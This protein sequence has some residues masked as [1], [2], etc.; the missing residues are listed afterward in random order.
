MAVVGAGVIGLSVAVNLSEEYGER[1]ELTVIAD[2]FSPNTTSD[3]AGSVI[4]PID[5]SVEAS[6][7]QAYTSRVQKWTRASFK[8]F[9]ALYKSELN[10]ELQ[11]RLLT[12]YDFK[13][14]LVSDPWWK[15]CVFGFRHID[16]KSEEAK[17]V[18]A[19][20]ESYSDIW[21]FT[22]Y[23]IDC[24]RYLPWM[25][26]IF[27][28][29]GGL[30]EQRR[31][32]N[33]QE[34][35]SYDIVINCTGL[36][37]NPL[38]N[39]AKLYP[40]RGQAILVRAPWVT[41]FSICY[42]DPDKMA[43]ILPRADDVLLGGTAQAHDWNES[44]DPKTADEIMSRCSELVPSISNA[45]VIDSWAGLRP[46]RQEVRLEMERL[47][48]AKRSCLIHCYGHGGQGIVLHWGCAMEVGELVGQWLS[49]T[50]SKL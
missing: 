17:L 6:S 37:A 47:N 50:F 10:S 23:M 15:D 14:T 27:T 13:S 3:K 21:V 44:T 4:I 11:I 43:Y 16:T 31:I 26:R 1:A 24:R 32:E 42:M 9:F 38:L 2:A 12:G 45:E 39:D 41:H 20:P 35:S 46:V 49:E 29:N 7:D 8:R 19:K 48:G 34:L 28:E 33:L 18:N 36:G 40:T 25:K 22:T 5:F 30:I